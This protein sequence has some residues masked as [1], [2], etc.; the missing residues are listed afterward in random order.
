ME[1][2]KSDVLLLGHGKVCI[3]GDNEL[4]L[5][6]VVKQAIAVLKESGVESATDE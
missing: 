2:I 5:A 4:A 6:Q 1:H 3:R